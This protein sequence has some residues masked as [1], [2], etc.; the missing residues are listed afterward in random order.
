MSLSYR[1]QQHYLWEVGVWRGCT[2]TDE[3]NSWVQRKITDVMFCD[4]TEHI[5]WNIW[6]CT[7]TFTISLHHRK[8]IEH[9]C[10]WL[11]RQ[12]FL[13]IPCLK[14]SINDPRAFSSASRQRLLDKEDNTVWTE[15]YMH[16]YVYIMCM[17][18]FK[19]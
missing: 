15:M 4:K 17:Y 10:M 8:I 13:G 6:F 5:L 16:I 7:S 12:Y 14:T 18:I 1:L 19:C 2:N 11:L 3:I 9:D